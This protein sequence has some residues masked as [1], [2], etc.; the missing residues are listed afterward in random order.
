MEMC[1]EIDEEITIPELVREGSLC[2]H[3]DFVCFNYPTEDAEQEIKRF[4]EKSHA[5]QMRLMQ[6]TDFEAAI[7]THR[8]LAGQM[9][10]EELLENPSAL[11]DM[12]LKYMK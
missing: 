3:Q 11:L 5:M 6:D 4:A 1:G 10:D 9:T 2:P 8:S 7:R 12:I